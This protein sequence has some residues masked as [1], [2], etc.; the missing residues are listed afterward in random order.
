MINDGQKPV[1][2]LS[3]VHLSV[4]I[5]VSAE[6]AGFA[7][8]FYFGSDPVVTP[9]YPASVG[10]TQETCTLAL[11]PHGEHRTPD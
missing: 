1:V 6:R 10:G 5:G 4:D 11:M 3:R 7:R 2:R 9:T 8:P